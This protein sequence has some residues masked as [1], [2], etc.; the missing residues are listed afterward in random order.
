MTESRYG[1]TE[2]S[3]V[4]LH[5]EYDG[6]KLEGVSREL[7]GKG[8]ELADGLRV[9]VTGMLL[10]TALVSVAREAIAYG[11]DRVL[12][13]QHPLLDPYTT[14][15]H[16]RVASQLI[17]DGKPDI[18]LLG[19]TPNGRDL[20][21]RLAVRLRTG[22]TAD[23][24]DLGL[25]QE[26]GLLLGEV[27]GFGG[28]IVA[29]IKCEQHR[30]QM[31]T[32]RPGVFAEPAPD[33]ARQ[34]AVEDVAVDLSDRD[35]RVRVVERSVQRSAGITDAELLVVGGAGTGGDFALLEELASLIGAELG[36]TRVAV[37][38]GWASHERQVGQTGYVTRPRLTLVCGVSGAQQFTV[39]IDQ[40]EVV[41]AVNA[42]GEAPIFDRADY[43]VV[44]DLFEVL[45]AMIEEARA[46]LQ[47]K[48]TAGALA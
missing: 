25:E 6:E 11:A 18:L 5:L 4:W 33:E 44:G 31:A 22:L 10:G 27:V 14:D 38:A 32:V 1:P 20:A 45:P 42:D 36:V 28:G 24:T 12:M 19:A 23:C 34:G 2:A 29:S 46:A 8:R 41:L 16:A 47:E 48:E 13:A 17:G 40:A 30:P 15:A 37:D 39:G 21:G 3:G 9:P 7:L 26:S 35:L 43:S